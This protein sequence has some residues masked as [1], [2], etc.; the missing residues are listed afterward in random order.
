MFKAAQTKAHHLSSVCKHWL[1]VELLQSYEATRLHLSVCA[2]FWGFVELRSITQP[3]EIERNR[4]CT[5]LLI[6]RAALTLMEEGDPGWGAQNPPPEEEE[7]QLHDDTDEDD[8]LDIDPEHLHFNDALD[9]GAQDQP[10]VGQQVEH[11]DEELGGAA[12]RQLRVWNLR[13]RFA[14][15]C[16]LHRWLRCCN[17][18]LAKRQARRFP[19]FQVARAASSLAAHQLANADATGSMSVHLAAFLSV[20]N[21]FTCVAP[22][23]QAIRRDGSESRCSVTRMHAPSRLPSAGQAS[24]LDIEYFSPTTAVRAFASMTRA[25]TC[26]YAAYRSAPAR[27]PCTATR[28]RNGMSAAPDSNTSID[29]GRFDNAQR[30][31][32]MCRPD[33][34]RMLLPMQQA[35]AVREGRTNDDMVKR[36][37]RK[38]AIT[39]CAFF[40]AW[41][42]CRITCAG[43]SCARRFRFL[44]GDASDLHR[45]RWH[46]TSGTKRPNQLCCRC[47]AQ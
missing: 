37:K 44:S 7:M 32:A 26:A 25:A 10:Q 2:T 46:V 28:C 43:G 47:S 22:S 8:G 3:N 12:E 18:W 20:R 27:T 11:M 41:L 6:T 16:A 9:W 23:P 5:S 31:R 35:G 45:M 21:D 42:A 17:L 39:E 40:F 1:A 24:A 19:R 15:M 38:N 30:A 14:G 34:V 33:F 4:L 13:G 29:H 36:L